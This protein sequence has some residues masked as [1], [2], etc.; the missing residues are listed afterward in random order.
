MRFR[1]L[2]FISIADDSL[3][4]YLAS[5]VIS[6]LENALLMSSRPEMPGSLLHGIRLPVV[7]CHWPMKRRL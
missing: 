1:P 6:P 2:L 7:L 3:L 4:Q 5:R